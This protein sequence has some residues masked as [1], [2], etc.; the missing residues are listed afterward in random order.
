MDC[1]QT[2]CPPQAGPAAPASREYHHHRQQVRNR[3]S[4]ASLVHALRQTVRPPGTCARWDPSQE[5]QA[6]RGTKDYVLTV[7]QSSRQCAANKCRWQC[8]KP[9]QRSP[10]RPSQTPCPVPC[11]VLRSGHT[12]RPQSATRTA[13]SVKS[14]TAQPY[15]R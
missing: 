4:V 9:A 1:R 2:A 12:L 5:T 11:C 3:V 7:P 8:T 6:A 10:A 13:L 15:R 14:P